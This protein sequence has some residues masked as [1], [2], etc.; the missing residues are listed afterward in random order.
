MATE[1]IS[2]ATEMH[3][4]LMLKARVYYCQIVKNKK[5]IICMVLPCLIQIQKPASM[6]IE[7]YLKTKE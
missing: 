4:F 2:L 5:Y 7:T 1:R 3:K 6:K